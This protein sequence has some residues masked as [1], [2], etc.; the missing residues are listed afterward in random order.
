MESGKSWYLLDVVLPQVDCQ[1]CSLGQV[2]CGFELFVVVQFVRVLQAKV[3]ALVEIWWSRTNIGVGDVI[4]EVDIN[5]GET[6]LDRP[7]TIPIQGVVL[8][9]V[10]D[11]GFALGDRA[12]DAVPLQRR[13]VVPLQVRFDDDILCLISTGQPPG[14]GAYGS[15]KMIRSGTASA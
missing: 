3:R 4:G 10:S 9:Y 12:V 7:I 1:L 15:W 6:F 13:P 2:F 5:D 14:S 11:C 8:V